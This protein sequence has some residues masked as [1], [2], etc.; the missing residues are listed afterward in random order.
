MRILVTGGA[1]FIGS[2]FARAT[3][4]GELSGLVGA[5]VTVLDKLTY[6]GNLANLSPVADH[7]RYQF[8]HGDTADPDLV[9][10]VVAGHDVIVHFAAETHVDRSIHSAREFVRSNIL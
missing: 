3:L 7:P 4:R 6:S 9:H 8:V 1:G 5:Q 2:E 10:E